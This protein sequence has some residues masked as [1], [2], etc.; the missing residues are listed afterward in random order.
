MLLCVW[1]KRLVWGV[2]HVHPHRRVRR[3]DALWLSG[4]AQMGS[5]VVLTEGGVPP[6]TATGLPG[7]FHLVGLANFLELALDNEAL[8]VVTAA[9]QAIPLI[10][11]LERTRPY[12]RSE[13]FDR[14]SGKL[15]DH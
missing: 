5:D 13:C 10:A 1:P 8:V 4:V 6:C 12:P 11:N 7:E 9:L 14:S 3:K 2:I 15:L